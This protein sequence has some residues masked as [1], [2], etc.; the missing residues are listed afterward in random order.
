MTKILVTTSRGLDGLLEQEVK[1]LIPDATTSVSPG[2]VTI[3]GELEDAYRLCLWSRL[4]NRVQW[5]CIS[6]AIKSADDLYALALSVD[7]PM[8]FT[9]SSTFIVQFNGTNNTINNSQFGTQTVKDAIVDCFSEMESS[10]PSVDR[11]EPDITVYA[12]LRRDKVSIGIDLSG[13]SLHQRHYRQGQ[14]GAPLKEHVAAAILMRSGWASQ[15]ELP[16]VD[17]M[18]GSGTIAIEAALIA[19]NI[20]PGMTR[21]TDAPY[22]WGFAHWNGH[23]L[24]LWNALCSQAKENVIEPT[25]KI[26]ASDISRELVSMAKKNADAAGV[27]SLISFSVSDATRLNC[28][29]GQ[30]GYL[31]SN[32]P[33]GERL[34]DL[35]DLLPLFQTWGKHLKAQW[36]DWKLSVLTS[37]RD[38]LRALKL[39]ASKEYALMNG[40]LECKLVNYALSEDNLKTLHADEDHPFSNRIKKNLKRLK[41]WIK[42][43]S[44]NCYRIYDSDLPEY[45]VAV[46]LYGDYC[47]VQEYAPPKTIDDAKAK[48]RLQDVM[49]YLPSALSL[50]S[51]NIVL[52]VRERKRGTSQYEKLSQTHARI[53]VYENGAKL[54]VNLWDYLDTGLFLDHR[55]TRALVK[56]QSLNKD[57]LNLFAYTGSVSVHAALGGAR[58]VTTVDMSNTYL[59]WAKENFA[60]NK[61]TGP[62]RFIK[63]DCTT[64]L[65]THNE[66]YDLIFVDPPSF[67]NSKKMTASW[68]VQ[69]DHIHLL[70]HLKRCLKRDGKILFSN[71]RRG[72]KL[73]IEQASALGL[74]CVDITK[75]TIPEDFA[76]H[77]NIHKCWTIT[78][79]N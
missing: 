70:A 6:G 20:A 1:S 59:E 72:F 9:T 10:R 3:D 23:N 14:G 45:N 19:K 63:T 46:D 79:A 74:H 77:A 4:A 39:R 61:I 68:D 51:K 57:V 34:N 60:L 47:V 44:T 75:Q 36:Q 29:K 33:Y 67:S 64:W 11:V 62:H 37:N 12:R 35:S 16:V 78:H 54:Y 25:T 42:K 52:K 32:P 49:L 48:R 53:E 28:P 31:V 41:P 17:P 13:K 38:L 40:K 30:S 2:C 56:Q 26:Y 22:D 8:H 65:E 69:R 43:Q 73:D 7:W 66:Q 21:Q 27:Y 55:E 58:S 76:R 50:S 5:E 24:R 15:T 71:N 18:C